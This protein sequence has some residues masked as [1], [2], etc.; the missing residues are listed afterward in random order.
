LDPEPGQRPNRLTLAAL[1]PD[2]LVGQLKVGAV[3]TAVC[4]LIV[5]APDP[6]WLMGFS[7]RLILDQLC[8]S[9]TTS[10]P[11]APSTRLTC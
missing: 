7:R 10:S 6:D 3:Q 8:A 1:P 9:G 4:G 11:S 5:T 2:P